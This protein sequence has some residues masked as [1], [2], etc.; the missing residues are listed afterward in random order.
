MPIGA[1]IERVAEGADFALVGC[2]GV[3]IDPR[4]QR[5]GQQEGAIHC[6]QLALPGAPAGLHVEK[7][8]VEAVVAGGVGL[9][10]LRAVPEESQRG[11]RSFHRGGARD[12][13]ALYPDRIRR[14]RKPVAAMLAGQSGAV[15]S[16]TSPLA[17]FV[18]VQEVAE[19]FA[20]QLLQLG[21][22]VPGGPPAH[23]RRWW[24]GPVQS[25]THS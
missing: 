8:I 7:M 20:L 11:Q 10:A 22:D 5:A 4:R 18:F 2:I 17:G 14:Q 19:G 3:E 16:I 12:E 6:R 21:I 1:A 25:R 23:G 15:L 9:G 13:S 24:L